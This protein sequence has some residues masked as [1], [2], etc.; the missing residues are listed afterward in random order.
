MAPVSV[1][2]FSFTD[3]TSKF[4]FPCDIILSPSCYN[5]GIGANSINIDTRRL[6]LKRTLVY[7]GK[8]YSGFTITDNGE[9]TNLATGHTYKTSEHQ[10]GYLIVYLPMGKRGKVKA[11]RVHKAVAETFIPN[12]ENL[13]V[14]HHIDGNKKNASSSNLQ[15]VSYKDNTKYYHR[16]VSSITP[17]FNNR[18]LLE[19]D[20]DAIR[21][22]RI[23]G[24]S[25][26]KIAKD[27]CVSRPTVSNVLHGISYRDIYTGS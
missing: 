15:W 8:L 4:P 24:Q 3:F 5:T 12:P 20:I 27:F 13:P 26:R 23:S 19:E 18:K 6:E 7:N 25:M 10:S 21:A 2:F 11:I 9:I 16:S 1:I 22:A 17:Y 14:V